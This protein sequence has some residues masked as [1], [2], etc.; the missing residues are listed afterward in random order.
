MSHQPVNQQE[1]DLP[2]GLSQPACRALFAAK[3]YRLE[4]LASVRES[5]IKKLHGIGP[6]T[7]KNLRLALAARGLAFADESST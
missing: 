5:E 2:D 1:I 3:Y 6:N 4:Q 7:L